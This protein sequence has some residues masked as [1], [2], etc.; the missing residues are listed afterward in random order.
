[1]ALSDQMLNLNC[2]LSDSRIPVV[3][4]R[5]RVPCTYFLVLKYLTLTW[6]LQFLFLMGALCTV[7]VGVLCRVTL[8]TIRGGLGKKYYEEWGY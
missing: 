7:K 4:V 1:M 2:L 5:W 3:K 8:R 6:D